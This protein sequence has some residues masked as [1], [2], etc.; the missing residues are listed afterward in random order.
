MDVFGPFAKMISNLP[1][2]GVIR[3]LDLEC[4]MLREDLE[5]HRLNVTDEVFSI[6]SF[7]QFIRMAKLGEVMRLFRPLP[8]HH[9]EFYKSTVERLVRGSELPPEAA[10]QFEYAFRTL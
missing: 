1:A 10:S 8:S 2:E 3:A 7:R 4:S 5:N 9:V 6:L